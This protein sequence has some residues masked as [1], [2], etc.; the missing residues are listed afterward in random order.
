MRIYRIAQYEQPWKMTQDAFVN[1]HYTGHIPEA[2]YQT[3]RD[4][5]GLSWLTKEKFPVLY[6]KGVFD[7]KEI[8]FRKSGEKLKYT[9]KVPEEDGFMTHKRDEEGNLVYMSDEEIK[10]RGLT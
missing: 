2:A 4:V 5:E 1:Y 7:G 6:A 8:E 9:H 3:Y 10:E